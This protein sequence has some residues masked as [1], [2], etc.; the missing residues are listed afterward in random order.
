MSLFLHSGLS[1]FKLKTPDDW[2]GVYILPDELENIQKA[3]IVKWLSIRGFTTQ[4]VDPWFRILG[5]SKLPAVGTMFSPD[6]LV[7][8]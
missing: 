2:G 6:C 7:S 3:N 4:N 5:V 1:L 8:G